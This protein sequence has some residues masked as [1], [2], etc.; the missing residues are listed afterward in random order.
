MECSLNTNREEIKKKINK[1]K[2]ISK[3]SNRDLSRLLGAG[4]NDID[5]LFDELKEPST[6]ILYRLESSADIALNF[7][8]ETINLFETNKHRVKRD[9]SRRR[10]NEYI[11]RVKDAIKIEREFIELEKLVINEVKGINELFENVNFSDETA[12]IVLNNVNEED[13]NSSVKIDEANKRITKVKED[14]KYKSVEDFFCAVSNNYK[15]TSKNDICKIIGCGYS[16]YFRNKDKILDDDKND[17]ANDHALKDKCK[18]QSIKK[19]RTDSNVMIELLDNSNIDDKKI[20]KIKSRI[21]ESDFK[22]LEVR[23]K[24]ADYMIKTEEIHKSV[25]KIKDSL[26]KE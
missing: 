1:I 22:Y 6:N 25:L 8:Q 13:F 19:L 5:D 16:T 9:I 14:Y 26:L 11:D 3:L 2:D 23:E 21:Q 15:I 20:N 24:I 7:S 4:T 17:K 12:D 10:V 18:L